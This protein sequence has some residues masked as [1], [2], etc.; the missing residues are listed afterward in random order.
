[1]LNHKWTA[2][3]ALM[4]I[5]LIPAAQASARSRDVSVE[6]VN[7]NG[8]A[9]EQF[10]VSQGGSAF[11][12][13]LQ[14]ERNAPYRIRVR[15]CTG[16][17][18]AVVVAVDGRNIISGAKS[19]L[20]RSEPMYILGP[21]E[22]Q[23]YSGW[24]TSLADV[25]EF[26]FTEW[27]NSYAEAF[28]DRSARGVIAVAAYREKQ[29]YQPKLSIAPDAKEEQ[30]AREPAPSVSSNASGELARSQADK[31]DAEPGTGFG[32]Q[33]HEPVTRIDFESEP[34]AS[35]RVFLKY[36]WRETLCQK[37]VIDCGEKNRFWNDDLAFAPFPPARNR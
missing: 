35:A 26:F 29:R 21:Y 14:A 18:V 33:R 4:A 20:E 15:N 13:Y 7:A 12:A 32:E 34:R 25:H 3:A 30:D 22:S 31:K 23:D 1:M 36:E 2:V 9:F 10:P 24:R 27:Q 19:E 28:G 6:I 11:R 8:T 5:G 16:Q 37:N 17:R